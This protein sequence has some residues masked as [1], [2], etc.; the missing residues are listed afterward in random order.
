[1]Q[2][3]LVPPRATVRVSRRSQTKF[4]RTDRLAD[5]PVRQR[6]P[7]HSRERG[8]E[9]RDGCHNLDHQFGDHSF[10]Y[11]RTRVDDGVGLRRTIDHMH[12][13]LDYRLSFRFE[14]SFSRPPHL[15]DLPPCRFDGSAHNYLC[16]EFLPPHARREFERAGARGNQSTCS[17]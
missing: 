1:M 2:C 6:F 12:D 10:G 5:R 16:F 3:R 17:G 15:R 13:A 11:L 8:N 14:L 7:R 4:I 9:K